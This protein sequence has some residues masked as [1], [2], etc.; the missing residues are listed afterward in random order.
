MTFCHKVRS[1]RWQVEASSRVTRL[2]S[3][4]KEVKSI[5][6]PLL[7]RLLERE[8]SCSIGDAMRRMFALDSQ[9]D[10]LLAVPGFGSPPLAV[11]IVIYR[12]RSYVPCR[13]GISHSQ[14]GWSWAPED[15]YCRKNNRATQ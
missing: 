1:R 8:C 12:T 11:K 13:I 6:S 5:A 15:V 4:V 14:P 3:L 2:L 10:E 7:S 9:A